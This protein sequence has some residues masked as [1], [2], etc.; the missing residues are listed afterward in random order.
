MSKKPASHNCNHPKTVKD[1]L[2][3]KR[4]EYGDAERPSFKEKALSIGFSEEDLR[5]LARVYYGP[6]RPEPIRKPKRN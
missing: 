5:R 6:A 4:H 2:L 1:S 3:G